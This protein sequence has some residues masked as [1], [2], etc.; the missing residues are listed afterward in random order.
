MPSIWCGALRPMA[1]PGF[2]VSAE[3]KRMY[4]ASEARGHRIGGLILER[5]ERL[6][7]DFGY[8]RVVLETGD[9]QPEAIRLYQ[10]SGYERIP[11]YG[12]YDGEARS[13]CFAKSLSGR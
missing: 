13:V 5:L 1:E 3:I 10:R 11:C 12:Q 9:A 4:V 8:E 6:P 2:A 7:R